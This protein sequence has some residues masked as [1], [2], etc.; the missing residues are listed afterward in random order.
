[1]DP[2][3]LRLQ[4]K[5]LA[6][7]KRE[8]IIIA[9]V[10]VLVVVVTYL[11]TR[12][13]DLPGDL[14]LGSSILI[15]ALIN[16]N[17]LLLLLLIFLV[18]RNLVK[19]M[20]E[21]RRGVL[22]ARLRTKLVVAFVIL[23]LAP[24][25]LLFFAAFQFVGTSMEYWF[26]AQVERSLYDALDVAEA[27]NQHFADTTAHFAEVV[28][29]DVL[30]RG[31]E[32]EAGN[33]R[34]AALAAERL[35]RY[36]LTA[37][38]IFDRHLNEVAQAIRSGT[39]IS[40]LQSF[41]LD[42]VSRAITNGQSL[43]HLQTAPTGDFAAAVHPLT[44]PKEGGGGV[45]AGA[46][47]V[48]RLMPPGAL[49][50]TA[51]IRQGLAGYRQLKAFKG[52][53]KTNQYIT[54]SI[55]TLLIIFAATWFGFYLAKT[56]TVP[57]MEVAQ[58]TQR[59]AGGDYDFFIQAEGPDEIGTL[60]NA[61]NRMTA[62]LKTSKARLD[63]AQREMRRTNLEL[64]E[65]RRNMEIILANV[66]AGVIAVDSTGAVSIF[67]P[68]AER[69][70]KTQGEAVLGQQWDSLL[71]AEH[72]QLVE[73]MLQG[74]TPGGRGAVNQQVRLNL[75]GETLTLM[76]HMSALR[77]ELGQ[78]LGLVVVFEDLTELEK[79]QRMAAWRE[80]ARRIAHE[81]KNPLTP[82]KLSAQRLM[83]RYG[84]LVPPEDTV[85]EECVQ[86]IIRQVEELRKLVSEFST[87]ARLPAARLAPADLVSIAEETLSLFK[88][89]HSDLTFQLEVDDDIPIFELDR[90]QIS[91]ALIN[92]VDNAVAAVEA[93]GRPG[94]V[95]IRLSH[96]D[97][98]KI[99]RLEVED[100]GPG[101]RPE[102]K[103]RLF[104]PYYSTK[105]TGT[106]LGLTI[107]STIVADHGGY[108]RVQDNDPQG[109][110]III[111]LPAKGGRPARSEAS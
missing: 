87:F 2:A 23:S 60:V 55:V 79:A 3:E 93:T 41:P 39:H 32:L 75:G 21:R 64:E 17:A 78:D 63:E 38:R 98:L 59:V 52:P 96:D 18:F 15:F 65:R 42:L 53:I 14:P 88:S 51:E 40:H 7:R 109:A 108:V 84:E 56:I 46:L 89:A 76:V 66:A 82:I 83:R 43:T 97:I 33:H 86:T 37:I 71:A 49:E 48:F 101:V 61:F 9:V 72:R 22:G 80:V 10:V 44:Y 8:R 16:I 30:Q 70:L 27:F 103:L 111:E 106:G 13:V 68:S 12:V 47:A 74:L 36:D 102:D 45:V 77:D 85:F 5:E 92:L 50:S 20:V 73:N 104:E 90:E 29:Q 25:I 69:L 19:L 107:V 58:G 105:K 67:N 110:R 95:T 4:K 28:A 26:S 99:V 57:L 6:R 94:Q 91:R 54:L 100:T 81:V 34:L 35:G 31:G 11:E 24:S 62:D 1:M